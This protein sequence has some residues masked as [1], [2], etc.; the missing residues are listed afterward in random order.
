MEYL[1]AHRGGRGQSFEYELL[2]NGEGETHDAF[3]MG[4]LNIESLK[5]SAT[6]TTSRG[7]Q[8]GFAG[9]SRP[10]RGEGAGVNAGG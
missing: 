6:T 10:Q 4:L 1:L 2:Y 7:K 9:P 3:L 8:G 5:N